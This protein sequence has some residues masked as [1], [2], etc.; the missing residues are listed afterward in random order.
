MLK[1]KSKTQSVNSFGITIM[2]LSIY[3]LEDQFAELETAEDIAIIFKEGNLLQDNQD[4]HT[5]NEALQIIGR[6][7]L[8]TKLD[9][10]LA[11]SK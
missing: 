2:Y 11:A 9:I 3:F 10:Y 4:I 1:T 8:A 5:F 7:D 6:I